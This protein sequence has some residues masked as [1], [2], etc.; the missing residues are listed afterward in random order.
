MRTQGAFNDRWTA[1][2]QSGLKMI[3]EREAP[4]RKPSLNGKGT[5]RPPGLRSW[6]NKPLRHCT[7]LSLQGAPGPRAHHVLAVGGWRLAV[8]DWRLVAVCGG[9]R[10]LVVGDWWLM[11]V[12]SGWRLAVGGRWQLVAVGGWRLVV[13]GGGPLSHNHFRDLLPCRA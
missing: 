5:V 4:C 11:V 2:S 3:D 6:L 1:A 13:V 12:G 7:V 10:Q 8:G 9:W